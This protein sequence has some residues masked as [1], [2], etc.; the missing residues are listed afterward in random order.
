MANEPQRPQSAVSAATGLVGLVGVLV[1][2]LWIMDRDLNAAQAPLAL[3]A[4][5]ALPMLLWTVLVE[6]SHQA[7]GL[8]REPVRSIDEAKT[9]T[10]TKLIG[11]WSTWAL[12]LFVYFLARYDERAEMEVFY[13]YIRTF[14]PLLVAL[15]IPYVYF[16]DRRMAEHR[17][18]LW[19]WG[20]F[21]CGRWD[22]VRWSML[23]D[24]WLGWTVKGFFLAFLMAGLPSMVK[25]MVE[26]PIEGRLTDP[27]ALT[28]FLVRFAYLIDVTIAV[29]GYTMTLRLLNTH[30]RSTNPHLT[31]WI[32]ALSCYAPFLVMGEGGP[33]DYR[34]HHQSWEVWLAGNDVML[35]VWGLSITALTA[36][37]AWA[38]V[39][40]GLRFS[41]LTHRG[42]ITNGP[43]R[44][45]RHPAYFAKNLSWWLVYM[46]FLSTAGTS[47]AIR[48][49]LLLGLVNL[50]Y[51][52]RALTEERHLKTDPD[53]VAYLNWIR[54]N[55]LLER[56]FSRPTRQRAGDTV[57]QS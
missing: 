43:Y 45:F 9:S 56:L 19:H 18:G 52:A 24:Y 48:A 38:T 3:I 33:L 16:V 14:G 26:M 1:A 20:Q 17:D 41:N 21:V 25:L 39:I 47:D 42:I 27:I 46:P 35:W 13:Y 4:G 8:S 29:V 22:T 50:I 23:K 51:V 2:Y 36:L 49:C 32:A 11:L 6:R 30:I 15:S 12:I 10:R 31:A 37:Y 53:Y 44:Y 7:S 55:G 40:F 5:A 28:N 34:A 54:E 57:R